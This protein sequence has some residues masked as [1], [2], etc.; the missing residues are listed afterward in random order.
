MN[1]DRPR[2]W[3]GPSAHTRE[4]VDAYLD[5]RTALRDVLATGDARQFRLFLQDAGEDLRDPELA[6]MG[7]WSEET[8]LPLMHRMVL[9]DAKLADHHDSSRQWLRERHMPLRVR[10]TGYGWS[11]ELRQRYR[12]SE[13]RSRTA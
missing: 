13:P 9:A 3:R 5:F 2:G 1:I 6:A 11:T 8:L 12:S 4:R 10:P 7:R